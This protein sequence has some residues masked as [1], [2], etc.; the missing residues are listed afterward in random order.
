MENEE[1]ARRSR[2]PLHD[3]AVLNEREGRA[4]NESR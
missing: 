2:M 1:E 4:Y 3:R